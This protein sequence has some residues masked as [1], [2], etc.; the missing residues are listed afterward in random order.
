MDSSR[1]GGAQKESI[2]VDQGQSASIGFLV[3]IEERF[4]EQYGSVRTLDP[5][6]AREADIGIAGGRDCG[7]IFR[8]GEVL[9]K[10][11][12]AANLIPAFMDELERFITEKK[13]TPCD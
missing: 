1:G 7:I 5:G 2:G 12:G 4:I 13:E 6:E 10:V 11:R 8:K 3:R 9:G